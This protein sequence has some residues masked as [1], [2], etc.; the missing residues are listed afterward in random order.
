[1]PKFCDTKNRTWTVAL[2][3]GAVRRV[4]DATSIDL[5]RLLG[6]DLRPL[7]ALVSDASALCHVV[8][9]LVKE[10][11]DA[12][13]PAVTADTFAAGWAG[14]VISAAAD[15]LLEALAE[16]LPDPRRR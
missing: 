16:Y 2:D 12:A 13:V 8:Y 7:A 10:Q 6:D 15:A 1:M 3:L 14:D 11:A 9:A 5:N 4:H